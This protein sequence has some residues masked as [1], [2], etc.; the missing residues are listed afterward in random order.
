MLCELVASFPTSCPRGRPGGGGV[1]RRSCAGGGAKGAGSFFSHAAGQRP[2]VSR[3]GRRLSHFQLV[4]S[5]E[6]HRSKPYGQ[7][8]D[9]AVECERHLVVLVVNPR[10]GVESDVKGLIS[11]LQEAIELACFPVATTLPSTVRT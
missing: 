3:S 10:T 7:L 9:L 4:R 2:L 8:V 11:H 6:L 5:G 1:C